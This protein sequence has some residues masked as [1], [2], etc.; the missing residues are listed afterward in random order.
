M[1]VMDK[2]ELKDGMIVEQ[3]NGDRKLVVN[4]YLV[5]EDDWGIL[6][7][8][9][10]NLKSIVFAES[11]TFE[12]FD[13]MRVYEAKSKY[14]GGKLMP[15]NNFSQVNDKDLVWERET[16]RGNLKS[17]L[18]TGMSVMLRNGG[19]YMVM[20]ST[21]RGDRLVDY[22]CGFVELFSYGNDLRFNS[23]SNFDV[24]KILSPANISL[25]LSP[26]K[27]GNAK[28]VTWQE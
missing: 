8:Y 9:G 2:S 3:R 18:K 23:D 28:Y 25:S 13:I 1:I 24:V 10:H 14:N 11:V 6:D 22:D 27:E 4:G 15:K 19:E 21:E 17:M 16:T 26:K 20:L 5:G 12:E 7:D